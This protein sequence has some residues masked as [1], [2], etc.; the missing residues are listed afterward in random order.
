MNS[1]KK[2]NIEFIHLIGLALPSKTTNENDQSMKDGGELWTRFEKEEIASKIPN[3]LSDEI[4]AVYFD[5]EGDHTQPFSY[6]IGCKV[7]EGTHVPDDMDSLTIPAGKYQ[8]ITAKGEMPD[9]MIQTWR[10]IWKSDIP[11]TYNVDF[12]VYDERSEDWSDAEVD[13]Y[14]SVK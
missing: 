2:F 9:C 14:L 5:Y 13:I 10:T 12:E 4:I 8:K 3:K 1:T 7:E 11:R 6:F